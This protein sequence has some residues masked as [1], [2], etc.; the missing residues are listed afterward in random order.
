MCAVKVDLDLTQVTICKSLIWHLK[1]QQQAELKQTRRSERMLKEATAIA[2]TYKAPL[3]ADVDDD[4]FH[5]ACKR[6]LELIV[7]ILRNQEDP[8]LER[9]ED[10]NLCESTLLPLYLFV[11][12]NGHQFDQPHTPVGVVASCRCICIVLEQA[13]C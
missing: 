8:K 9:D 11:S 5:S 10:G 4:T 7:K 12:T 6:D 13:T 2:S 3:S 1:V